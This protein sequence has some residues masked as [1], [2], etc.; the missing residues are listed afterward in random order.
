MATAGFA[1]STAILI[2]GCEYDG[3]PLQPVIDAFE[4]LAAKLVTLSTA[5]QATFGGLVH[6]V[7]QQGAVY[8]WTVA[9]KG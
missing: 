4:T 1:G 2:Y 5:S 8:A 3:F 9:A 6:P 7:H